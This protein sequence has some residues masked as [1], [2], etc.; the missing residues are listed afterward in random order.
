VFSMPVLTTMKTCRG[1]PRRHRAGAAKL[2]KLSTVPFSRNQ[3]AGT[4]PVQNNLTDMAQ[5]P[6]KKIFHLNALIDGHLIIGTVRF[7][8]AP[9]PGIFTELARFEAE[10]MLAQLVR[11]EIARGGL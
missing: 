2:A 9:Q 8:P 5:R 11:E 7:S 10:R 4:L 6:N 3:K 1:Q